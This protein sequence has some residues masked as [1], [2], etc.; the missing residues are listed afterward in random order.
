MNAPTK[1]AVVTGATGGMGREIVADL[2]RDHHVIALGRNADKL[3]QLAA[4][5]DT[6]TTVAGDLTGDGVSALELPELERVD[7]LVHGAAIARRATVAEASADEWRA[8]LDLNV[9]A[10]ALLT[11]RLLPALRAAG[12]TV[13]FINS[14]EGV[15]AHPNNT[16]Y[17]A[18]KHALNA[19]ADSLRKEEHGIRVTT[20]APGPTDTDMLKGLQDYDPE[21]VIAPVEVAHAIRA[22][23]DAG[24]TTQLTHINVRPRIELADR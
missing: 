10:P 5:N 16:P 13:C 15:G 11:Q 1:T 24:E 19:L 17:A 4:E 3:A 12:G 8:H 7:V 18:S 6:V 22:A 20:V 21:T 9:V 23:V 14:G 2:A